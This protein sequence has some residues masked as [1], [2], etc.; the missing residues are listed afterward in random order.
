MSRGAAGKALEIDCEQHGRS[1]AASVCGH[2]VRNFG[3]PLGFVENNDDP[4]DKQGWC[5]ACEL[6]YD[7]ERGMT[8][9]FVAFCEHTVV[10][11]RCYD[12]IKARHDFD[13]AAGQS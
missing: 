5:Y 1:G 7:Q 2:L 11:S 12:E 9:R 4:A 6:V 8:P 3:V 10:C 13:A